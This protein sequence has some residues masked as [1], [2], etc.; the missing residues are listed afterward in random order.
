MWFRSNTLRVLCP[1]MLMATR[2]DTPALRR[3]RTAVRRIGR[4]LYMNEQSREKRH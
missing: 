4:C 2:S 1:A 3:F